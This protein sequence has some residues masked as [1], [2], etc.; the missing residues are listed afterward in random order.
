[1]D[2]DTQQP[3]L[4][5]QEAE[6]PQSSPDKQPWQEPKLTFVEPKLTNHGTLAEI[7]GTPPLGGFT[8]TP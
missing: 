5:P 4:P 6:E 8:P 2:K 3:V 1:V 7:T